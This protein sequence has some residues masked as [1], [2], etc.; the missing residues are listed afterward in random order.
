MSAHGTRNNG[1]ISRLDTAAI[2][3][4]CLRAEI[5][6]KKSILLALQE[7]LLCSIRQIGTDE[8]AVLQV[9]R[10]FVGMGITGSYGQLELA[11]KRTGQLSALARKASGALAELFG[12]QSV[13]QLEPEECS[14]FIEMAE[15][16]ERTLIAI[17]KHH[18]NVRRICS[19]SEFDMQ[20]LRRTE[21]A[22]RSHIV[23]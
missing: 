7:N 12:E 13:V 4:D 23:P 15:H 5:D 10:I 2:G 20:R 21:D 14:N 3:L 1:A 19:N 8:Q 22:I 17:A 18:G 6:V 11:S 9:D 16:M